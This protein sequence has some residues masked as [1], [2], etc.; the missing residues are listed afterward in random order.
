MMVRHVVLVRLDGPVRIESVL[1]AKKGATIPLI[2]RIERR[3]GLTGDVALAVTGLPAGARAD[4][5]TVKAGASAFTLNVVLPPGAPT[6]EFTGLK[7]S[8]TAAP[9]AKQPNV[10]VRSPEVEV[11]LL[12]RPPAK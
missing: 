6:G 10:R 4:A 8:A 5:V 11:T 12:V 9:D 1:D 3:E 7:L 2:G